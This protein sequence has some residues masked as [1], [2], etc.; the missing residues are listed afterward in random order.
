MVY[1]LLKNPELQKLRG[2]AIAAANQTTVSDE[3]KQSDICSESEIDEN[4]KIDVENDK[5]ELTILEQCV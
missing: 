3:N 1:T 4:G 2:H 5:I